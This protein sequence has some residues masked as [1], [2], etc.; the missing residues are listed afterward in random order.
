MERAL[1]FTDQQKGHSVALTICTGACL[2]E[3]EKA[4]A[5]PV[6]SIAIFT[7]IEL[8][9]AW[10]A[11]EA[12]MRRSEETHHAGHGRASLAARSSD[13][14]VY[15]LASSGTRA[16]HGVH[17]GETPRPLPRRVRIGIPACVLRILA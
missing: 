5:M 13:V 3:P 1:I 7:F 6:L 9:I 12:F 15:T 11:T 4:A 17:A 10:G 16:N 2:L 14:V 8:V